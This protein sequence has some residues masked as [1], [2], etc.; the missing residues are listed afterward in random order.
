M[1][2]FPLKDP[3]LLEKWENAVTRINNN[4]KVWRATRDSFICSNHFEQLDYIT[5]PTSENGTCRLKKNAVPSVFSTSNIFSTSDL[6]DTER[7]RLVIP[8]KHSLPPD[9]PD[10]MSPAAKVLCHHNYAKKL[11]ANYSKEPFN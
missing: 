7:R 4:G 11:P 3:I 8:R 5:P 10:T 6:S 9:E 1:Y 2:R